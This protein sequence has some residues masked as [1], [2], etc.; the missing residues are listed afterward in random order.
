MN[1]N[2]YKTTLTISISTMSGS[3][4]KL[5][6]NKFSIAS[7]KHINGKAWKQQA[8]DLVRAMPR[9]VQK[10]TGDKVSR[11][12]YAEPHPIFYK[13]IKI[14][15]LPMYRDEQT[16]LQSRLLIHVNRAKMLKN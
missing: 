12:D 15:S 13:C 7:P 10:Q 14:L 3:T 11:I 6:Y 8:R 1:S 5:V 9:R 4:Q 16:E 2:T